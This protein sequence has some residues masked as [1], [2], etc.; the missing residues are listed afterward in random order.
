MRRHA[1]TARLVA[2]LT[3]AGADPASFRRLDAVTDTADAEDARATYLR[4]VRTQ[5]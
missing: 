5:K 1:L 2:A 4:G 3:I